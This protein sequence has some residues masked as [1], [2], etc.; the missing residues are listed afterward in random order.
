M[1][2][3]VPRTENGRDVD[4]GMVL[5]EVRTGVAPTLCR[6]SIPLAVVRHF[7]LSR[8]QRQ[9]FRYFC[10]GHDTCACAENSLDFRSSH[11]MWDFYWLGNCLQWEIT[12][13]YKKIL[14]FAIRAGQKHL[15]AC[16]SFRTAAGI[17]RPELQGSFLGLVSY[18][19]VKL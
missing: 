8:Q 17:N 14:L 2:A 15:F 5:R 19:A 7:V 12:N 18:A 9:H 3:F 10:C 11:K 16:S 6:L 4:A 1:N 13:L